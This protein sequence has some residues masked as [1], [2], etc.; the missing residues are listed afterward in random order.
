MWVAA[1]LLT[2]TSNRLPSA[3]PWV[4]VVVVDQ[5]PPT[6][7]LETWARLS[8]PHRL[9]LLAHD[10]FPP[11]TCFRT[12]FHVYASAG[13]GIGYNTNPDTVKCESPVVIGFSHWLRQLYGEDDLGA[14]KP[15]MPAS[16]ES[17]AGPAAE[18]AGVRGLRPPARGIVLKNVVWLSR[19]C[20]QGRG[21][22]PEEGSGP[23]R[24]AEG[25][26]GEGRA[27]REAV[28][29]DGAWGGTCE[30]RLRLHPYAS[31]RPMQP[32]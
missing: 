12:A 10:P 5:A 25:S 21:A 32:G 8:Q 18:A 30:R 13:G 7:F 20:G 9:R 17:V 23:G 6:G 16:A 26:G 22:G 15:A 4:Q 1:Q 24:G 27:T 14:R 31:R 29:G 28:S 11:N 19:R 2:H 3:A